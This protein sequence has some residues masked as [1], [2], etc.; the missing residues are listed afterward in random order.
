MR[1]FVLHVRLTRRCNADCVYCSSWRE[2]AVGP[3]TLEEFRRSIDFIAEG[4]L[5]A[6]GLGM[7]GGHVSI[8]Y[9]G[10]EILTVPRDLLE[11][12]VL[13]ARERLARLF[14][15]VT[16]GAQT[17]MLGT[18]CRVLALHDLFGERIGISVD[19]F[20]TQ[21]RLAGS[22]RSYRKLLE[23]G[24]R[25]ALH[26][27]GFSPPAVFVVDGEGLFHA[28]DE[29]ERAE[30][31]GHD[32]TLRP[33]F[34]GSRHVRRPDAE[35]IRA[36]YGAIFEAWVMNK[37]ILVQPFHQLLSARLAT[38]SGDGDLFRHTAGCPFQCDCAAAS[39]D[40]EP[41]GGLYLCLDMADADRFRLGN[42]LHRE[43]DLDTWKVLARRR[44]RLDAR[45]RSCRWLAEC[46]GGC[47][48]E[49]LAHSGDIYGVTDLCPVWEDLFRRFD[50][51]IDTNGLDAVRAWT[52][53]A[54]RAAA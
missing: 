39:L 15:Q 25:E 48:S 24:R 12:C 53:G 6:M 3:M 8:Q 31:L 50:Q 21:R 37:R 34:K 30:R 33:V 17:N 28:F 45:C 32:L 18:A 49:G 5:P 11:N 52:E 36:V 4:V 35:S 14:E 10:G 13:Y 38:H 47:M 46:R 7:G 42:A 2:D 44:G 54:G 27:R 19:S 23:T 29:V 20:G 1:R 22:P 51:T 16:D 40:L 26:R 43:F 41:D 9:V